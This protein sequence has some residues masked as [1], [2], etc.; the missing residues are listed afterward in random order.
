MY[1]QAPYEEIT[2]DKYNEEVA[3]FPTTIDFNIKEEDDMTTA[4]QELACV[5]G[6][7]DL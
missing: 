1:P 5:G 2:E 3:K 7:C 6:A 4:S